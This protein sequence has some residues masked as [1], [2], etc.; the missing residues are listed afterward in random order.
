M[1]S[2]YSLVINDDRLMKEWD[3]DKNNAA[4]FD[5]HKLTCGSSKRVFWK[6]SICG[7]EW[8]TRISHRNDGSGCK[9]CKD[10]Q[11]ATCNEEESLATLY[12]KIA[13]E[14]DYDKNNVLPSTVYPL[15]NLKY[16]WICH[17]GHPYEDSASHRVERN[18]GCPYCSGKKILVGFNDLQTTHPELMKDWDWDKNNEK[19]LSPTKVSKGSHK[20]AFWKC[21]RGHTWVAAIY[22]RANGN[23]GC[24]ECNA[25]LRT[26][27][28]EKIV[29]YYISKLFPD[30]LDNYR[31][32]KLNK[33]ELDIFIPSLKVGIEYDG[34]RWHKNI[35]N[36]LK[37][38]E[39]CSK[40][41]I[42]LFRIR[43]E[44]CLLYESGSIKVYVKSK[45]MND[46]KSAIYKIANYINVKFNTHLSLDID[47]D[48]DSPL[49][50]S[51]TLSLIKS[52]S[53]INT[54]LMKSWDWNK[55]KGINPL[56]IPRF[57][58]RKF[59]WKC[60]KCGYEWRASA[61]HRSKGRGCAKCAGQI[62]KRNTI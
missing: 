8:Q 5:P 47:I 6:C 11:L 31:D 18:S 37:K 43:E 12:P 46:L 13:K 51:R 48:R 42:T 22:S 20:K 56:Y 33:Y 16:H 55:N 39:L 36:D 7:N 2:K 32:K 50:L 52:N 57:S 21:E 24:P 17:L 25:E 14:W 61:A 1:K 27:Y 15:S 19:G 34:A 49:I 23:R 41:G 10:R 9:K 3:W 54:P 53:I 62:K 28:P 59:M 35:D 44:K 29:S 60:S 40:Y 38:D 45:N 26:S 4:C 58:N 30:S